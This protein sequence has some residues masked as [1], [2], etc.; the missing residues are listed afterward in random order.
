MDISQ[1][2]AVVTGG[3]SGLG[4]A[5]AERVV[6]AGGRVTILDLQQEAGEAT[7]AALG[8]AA[9][10]TRCNVAD[11][12]AVDAAVRGAAKAMGSLTLAMACAGIGTAG[13]LLGRDGPLNAD[14]FHKTLAVNLF[15]TFHLGRVAA[16]VMQH[17]EPNADGERGLIVHTA[18]VAAYEGQIGQVAYSASKAGVIGMVIPMAR[19]LARYGIRVMAIAPGLFA[20]PMLAGLPQEAQ[21]SLGK[22]VPFPSRL[23]RPA[24][25]A[26]LVAAIYG[27]PMLNGEAI[28]LDGAIRMAPK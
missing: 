22:Q 4:R 5:V 18:S 27:N 8:K 9:S 17:N 15:G 16:D 2:R 20:T 1:A 11:A 19:E 14:S 6:E 13:K 25:F 7:A 3:A 12:D 24:E 21:D 10:F 26:E 28:R 23:G